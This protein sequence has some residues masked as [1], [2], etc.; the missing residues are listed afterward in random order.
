L[1]FLVFFSVAAAFFYKASKQIMSRLY[2][3]SQR[4]CDYMRVIRHTLVTLVVSLGI[5]DTDKGIKQSEGML[6]ERERQRHAEV[7]AAVA[8][9]LSIWR[10]P[11]WFVTNRLDNEDDE[12]AQ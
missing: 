7:D 11:N 4:I 1:P 2:D 5:L 8:T 12:R 6:S 9:R 10:P 3:M